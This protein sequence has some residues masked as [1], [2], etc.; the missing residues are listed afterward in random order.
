M[1]KTARLLLT[2]D[3]ELYL[4]WLLTPSESRTPK[5]KKEF[6]EKIEIHS[7]TLLQWEK[8]KTFKERWELGIKGLAQSPERTQT[9]LDALYAK[10]I[11]GD[12]R[13]AELYLKA[14]G[15]M[16]AGAQM[17][18][19]EQTSVKDLSDEELESMILELSEKQKKSTVVNE[20]KGK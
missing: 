5:T 14:T 8:N 4:E 3:Q 13:S 18:Q 10:G 1:P 16:A 6:A 19:K 9:L 7:N 17:Q 15:Q 11:A 12:H 2:Q 20:A